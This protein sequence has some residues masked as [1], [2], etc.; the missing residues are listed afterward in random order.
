VRLD[1]SGYVRLAA[2]EF[3]LI[4]DVGRIGPDY[5]P[6]HAHADT[7]SFELSWRGRRVFGNSGTSCYG[8]SPQRVRER[9]TAAHNTV[10]VDDQDSSEVWHGFRVARRARPMDLV[11]ADGDGHATVACAHDGYR[12]LR[13]RPVHRRQWR[14]AEDELVIRDHI[15]GA[16][17]HRA[18]GYLHVEPGIEVTRTGDRVFDL[19]VAGAG[20]LRLSIETDGTVHLGEGFVGREFGKLLPR[21]VIQW[22]AAGVL[23]LIASVTI[24]PR[25]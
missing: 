14:L 8:T 16:G 6:G 7:L 4:T 15:E 12:R 11:I 20:H 25:P 24:A 9:G 23:P 5:I 22:R 10:T 18:T 2:G 1:A 17:E 19:A 13:G 21:P 3:V